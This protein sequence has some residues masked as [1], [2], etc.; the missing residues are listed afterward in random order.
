MLD[1][2]LSQEVWILPLFCYFWPSKAHIERDV[3]YKRAR[4]LLSQSSKMIVFTS[5][6]TEADDAIEGPESPAL[7]LNAFSLHTVSSSN[8]AG[9]PLLTSSNSTLQIDHDNSLRSLSGYSRQRRLSRYSNEPGMMHW[10]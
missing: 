2:I 5:E 4:T 1:E 6:A 7:D 3:T 10:A 8:A 9:N